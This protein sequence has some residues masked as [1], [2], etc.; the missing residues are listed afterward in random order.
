MEKGEPK[1]PH[2]KAIGDASAAMVLAR[3]VQAGK[4]ILVPFGENQRYDLVIDEGDKFTRVQCKTGRIR[5]GAIFFPTCSV[6]YHHPSNHGIRAYRHHY[7][8]D[9]ELFGVYCPDN[10]SV[11]LVPVSEVGKVGASLRV[12]PSRNGQAERIRWAKDYHL[13]DSPG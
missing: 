8:G 13:G 12:E 7:Q 1:R 10:D 3:L 2:T 4:E 6:T 5:N 9:A 11:Y